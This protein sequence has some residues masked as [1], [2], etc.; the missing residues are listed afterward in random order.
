[1]RRLNLSAGRARQLE[2]RL[3]EGEVVDSLLREENTLLR[4]RTEGL[5][6]TKT[7]QGLK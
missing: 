4:N 6:V 7:G 5:K 3:R 2:V 1:M